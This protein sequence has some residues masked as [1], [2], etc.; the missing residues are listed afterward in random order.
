MMNSLP[1]PSPGI[2]SLTRE[3]VRRVG[4]TAWEAIMVGLSIGILVGTFVSL[5]M[6]R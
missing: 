2:P 3:T 1:I 6:S 4:M 5:L